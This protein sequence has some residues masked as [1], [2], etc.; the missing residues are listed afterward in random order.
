MLP[1]KGL[2]VQLPHKKYGTVFLTDIRDDFKENP[3]EDYQVNQV[4]RSVFISV[5][6]MAMIL[7]YTETG[8]LY[9]Q[10]LEGIHPF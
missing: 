3:A 1:R 8:K 9:G 2:A 5:K 7:N 10:D 6:I 4:V